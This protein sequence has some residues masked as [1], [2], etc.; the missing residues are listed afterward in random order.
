MIQMERSLRE[1]FQYRGCPICNV[2]DEEEEYFMAQL[3]YRTIK[4]DS[5][6]QEIV[7]SNGYCNFHFYEL[8]RLSSPMVNAVLTKNLIEREIIEIESRSLESN[9]G[10][11]CSV[12]RYIEERQNLFL[13]EFET[14]LRDQTFRGQYEGTDGLCRIHLKKVLNSLKEEEV[15]QFFLS[16]QG[17]HL[18]LLKL[19]LE[20]FISKVRST[21][22]DMGPEKDAWWVAIEKRVGKK[23]LK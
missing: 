19:E 12:C 11:D 21:S 18:K 20:A 13:R 15:L 4:E 1:A 6:R 10:I 8:A 7:A 23:G 17:M 3:Q 14:L 2:L 16:T 9:W 5:T 22:R